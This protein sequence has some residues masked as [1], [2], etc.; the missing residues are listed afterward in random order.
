MC[1]YKNIT[2]L[3]LSS[4]PQLF[5]L[6]Y[7][8]VDLLHLE[9]KLIPCICQKNGIHQ[10]IILLFLKYNFSL[11]SYSKLLSKS[12]SKNNYLKNKSLNAII[13]E[14][15]F[16]TYYSLFFHA[17]YLPCRFLKQS[18]I[19]HGISS[20]YY[21]N[22]FNLI[23]KQNFWPYSFSS[24]ISIGGAKLAPPHVTNCWK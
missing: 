6:R 15:Q 13:S 11:H 5:L 10:K 8:G 9:E 4:F 14:L 2:D 19:W 18:E 17:R 23:F 3:S 1:F 12:I 16:W 20:H 7:N 22:L 21:L 24:Q